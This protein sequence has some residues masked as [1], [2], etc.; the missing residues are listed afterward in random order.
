VLD[1]AQ[2]Q[3]Y[4]VRNWHEYMKVYLRKSPITLSISRSFKK[5]DE[6]LSYIG[7]LF[8]FLL[9]FLFFVKI[10]NEYSFEI[11]LTRH[12]YY[13]SENEPFDGNFFNFLRFFPYM[14]YKICHKISIKPDWPMYAKLHTFLEEGRKQL[15]IR[16]ITKKILLV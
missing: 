1:P 15:D 12:S 14:I 16:L 5:V 9:L 7:G 13:C 6:T 10:Y 8:S 4:Q 3:T 2:S 11:E